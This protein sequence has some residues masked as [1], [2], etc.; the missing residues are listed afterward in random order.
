MVRAGSLAAAG[1]SRLFEGKASGGR[2]DRPELAV[3]SGRKTAAQ[4]ARIFGLSPR[5]CLASLPIA[6]NLA[7]L[8]KGDMAERA[9]EL[10][11]GTGWPPAMLRAG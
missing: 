11:T 8:K 9:A 6:E 7:A 3:V 5:Q 4:M 1:C 2:W 10:L